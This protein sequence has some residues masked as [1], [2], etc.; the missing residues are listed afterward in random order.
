MPEASDLPS[1]SRALVVREPSD[2][3]TPRHGPVRQAAGFL[4]HLIATQRRLPQTRERRRAEPEDVIAAYKA[5]IAR[6]QAAN[7]NIR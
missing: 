5:T 1:S 4:A 2:S 6:L 7:E 3:D